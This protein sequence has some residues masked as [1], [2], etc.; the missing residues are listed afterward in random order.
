MKACPLASSSDASSAAALD[1]G[2]SRTRSQG[3]P[4]LARL[5]Q[6]SSPQRKTHPA[7][8]VGNRIRPRRGGLMGKSSR[9]R[10]CKGEHAKNRKHHFTTP[11]MNPSRPAIALCSSNSSRSINSARVDEETGGIALDQGPE[12]TPKNTDMT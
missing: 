2:P 10:C 7:P 12:F 4:E 11:L 3:I 6:S 5:P 8:G 1:L 9:P